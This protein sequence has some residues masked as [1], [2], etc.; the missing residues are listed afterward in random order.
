MG[1]YTDKDI[2][3]FKIIPIL[4]L[5]SVFRRYLKYRNTGK[6]PKY[7]YFRYFGIQ[8]YKNK[9]SVD[10][11]RTQYNHIPSSE[12]LAFMYISRLYSIPVR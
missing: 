6:I 7:R 1:R 11:L 10:C 3:I 5:T 8:V 4:I 12:L 2:A 9:K